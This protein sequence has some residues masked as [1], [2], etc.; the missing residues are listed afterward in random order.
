[1]NKYTIKSR[2]TADERERS[3]SRDYINKLS[4]QR[5]REIPALTGKEQKAN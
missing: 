5:E 4:R 2:T 1:M 3:I